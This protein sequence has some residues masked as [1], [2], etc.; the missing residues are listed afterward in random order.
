M[1]DNLTDQYP[2]IPMTGTLECSVTGTATNFSDIPISS[3]QLIAH[4]SNSGVA[5]VVSAQ[6]SL[7]YP[8]K[9]N[10]AGLY[11]DAISSLRQLSIYFEVASDKICY[12]TQ[13]V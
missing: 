10:Q 3:I 1:P 8:L 5:W 4:P 12:I 13:N 11:L 6:G 7:G 2:A 9:A